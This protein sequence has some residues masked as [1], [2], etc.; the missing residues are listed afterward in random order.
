MP[1]LGQGVLQGA[2]DQP[3]HQPGIAETHFGLGR[4]DIDIDLLA[5]QVE[6]QGHLVSVDIPDLPMLRPEDTARIASDLVENSAQAARTLQE[7]GACDLSF[8]V[9]ERSRFRVVGRDS[10][11]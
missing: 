11:Q 9:P 5:G 8:S 4:V 6:K 2:D 7:Q 3:A 10:H 1:G